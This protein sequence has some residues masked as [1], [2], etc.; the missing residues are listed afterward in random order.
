M[1]KV[2]SLFITLAVLV[3]LMPLGAFIK[4]SE[5]KSA[6]GGKRAFHMCSMMQAKADPNPSTTP[7]FQS[8]SGFEHQAKSQA[9][10]GG[11][12]FEVLNGQAPLKAGRFLRV[13][14]PLIFFHRERLVNLLDPPP[15]A[16]PLV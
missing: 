16:R 13:G 14:D 12:E 4:P 1:R 15:E 2:V 7:V 8:A 11:N 6:C 9:S 5:E 10:G 3:W